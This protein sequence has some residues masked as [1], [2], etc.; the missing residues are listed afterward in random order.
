MSYIKFFGKLTLKWRFT[1]K[2]FLRSTLRND[3]LERVGTAALGKGRSLVVGIH[4]RG[5]SWALIALMVVWNCIRVPGQSLD[6]SYFW[7]EGRTL[8]KDVSFDRKQFPGK[9]QLWEVSRQHCWQLECLDSERCYAP[10]HPLQEE[11][12]SLCWE[13]RVLGSLSWSHPQ[14][15]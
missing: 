1:C 3:T 10:K 14:W 7:G 6:M 15:C 13:P 11:G 8:G 12:R 5:Q 9:A 4:K 2:E